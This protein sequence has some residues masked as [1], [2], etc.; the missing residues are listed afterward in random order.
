MG[1]LRVLSG[2]VAIYVEGATLI[3]PGCRIQPGVAVGD[4]A[5]AHRGGMIDGRARGRTW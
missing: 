1:R 2:R 3:S 4:G 5:P